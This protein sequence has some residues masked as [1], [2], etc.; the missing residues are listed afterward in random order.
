ME[1]NYFNLLLKNVNKCC[2]NFR[3]KYLL[4]VTV[5]SNKNLNYSENWQSVTKLHFARSWKQIP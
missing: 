1:K 2:A 4:L 3:I 5:T